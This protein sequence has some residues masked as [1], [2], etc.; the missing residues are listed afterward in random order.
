MNRFFLILFFLILSLP[1]GELLGRQA[2]SVV[3]PERTEPVPEITKADF[4]PHGPLRFSNERDDFMPPISGHAGYSFAASALIPGLGQAANRNFIR[5]ALFITVEAA[6]VYFMLDYRN[7]GRQGER[8]YEAFADRNWSVVQYANWLV[9]YHDVHGIE[10]PHLEAL[11]DQIEGTNPAF[12][13]NIDWEAVDISVLRRAERNTPYIM[14]DDL[15]ASNFSHVLPDYGSQQYYEL[16]AKYYQYQAGWSD[17]N[18]FHND[19]GHTGEMFNRRYL[20]DRN[21]EFASPLFWEGADRSQLFNDQ[22]RTGRNFLSLLMVNHMVSAFDA[23][24][25]VRLRENR[26]QAVAGV[27]PDRYL[28]MRY[29]F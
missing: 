28:S 18:R 15:G 20:I 8:R 22:F 19:L 13:T 14:T 4:L 10:N 12:D 27:V 25:T 3:I 1:A 6:A 23:Y 5:S 16:I 11:R 24:F 26:I 9:E 17:Y 2:D 21:G 29:R 7:R